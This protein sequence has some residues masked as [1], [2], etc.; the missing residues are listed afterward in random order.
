MIAVMFAIAATLTSPVPCGGLLL[1]ATGKSVTVLCRD[2]KM[3]VFSLEDGKLLRTIDDSARTARLA[4]SNISDDGRLVVLGFYDGGVEIVDTSTGE[5]QSVRVDHY[6]LAATFSHDGRLL[7][8]APG[9]QPMRILDVVSKRVV[10]EFEP[11]VYTGAIAFSRDDTRIAT[12]EADAVAIYDVKGK[13]I[14]RNT[15]FRMS[16]LTLDFAADGKSLIAGGADKVAV[17]IDAATG[18]TL[19]RMP[20]PDAVMWTAV[21]PDGKHVAVA[22]MNADDTQQAS[23][24]VFSDLAGQ[25][26]SQ[27]MPPTGLIGGGWIYDGHF[28]AA[29]AKEGVVQLQRV[30]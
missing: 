11:S 14:A 17:V 18:R 1:P 6:L 16:P 9:A 4:V 24:V 22:T 27:S 29:T 30:R 20:V 28:V 7:A 8:M 2:R 19:R 13:R 23:P 26:K 25:N 3:R 21:S 10:T 15:D 12:A 5:S